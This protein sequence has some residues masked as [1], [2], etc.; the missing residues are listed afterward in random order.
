MGYD[1][2]AALGAAVALG[3]KQR[4]ICLAGDGSIMMNLQELQTIR[5]LGLPVKVFILNNRGYHS[6]RQT[7]AN[8]FADNIVGCGTDSG[9][10]FPDFAKI[11]DA[12]G[13]PYRRCDLHAGLETA[14]RDTLDGPG[15]QCCEI[16]LDLAQ[17]FAPKLTS[18]RLPSGKMVSSPL[19]D[20][21][22]FLSRDELR[23]N[24]FI[25]LVPEPE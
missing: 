21:A 14:I 8:F 16:I 7:Q 15:P 10:S 12:F 3:G 23:Q 24:M 11:A 20:M 13:F 5:G 17:P 2:P 6:I 19:E 4:V 9:L 1:L 18:R 25:P 22:P